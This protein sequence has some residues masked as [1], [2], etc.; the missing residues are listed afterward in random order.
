MTQDATPSRL[1]LVSALV[2]VYL[3]WGST[4]LAIH[5]A[6]ESMPPFLMAGARWVLAGALLYAWRRA[7]GDAAPTWRNW[8][9]AAVVGM[10][11][12]VGGNGLVSWAQ[13][14]VPSGF[15][16]LLIA[17]VPVWMALLDWLRPGGAA[18]T[19]RVWA[20]VLLGLAGVSLLVGPAALGRV[21]EAGP[22]FLAGVG[23]ILLASFSWANGSL[24]SR[25]APMPKSSLLGAAMQMLAGGLALTALGL[26]SGE[27]REV[28]I[29]A[30]SAR[31]WLAWG[32]LVVF[33]S[34]VA[35]SAYVWLLKVTRAELVATYAFVNPV[36]AVLLGALLAGE[37]FSAL[38]GVA[39]GLIVLAVAVIVTAPRPGAKAKPPVAAAS[40]MSKEF[41]IDTREG[42][43]HRLSH[44]TAECGLDRIPEGARQERES[45]L[46]ATMVMKTRHYRACPRC[47]AP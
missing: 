2:A 19:P 39:A 33:G 44:A 1:A 10:L 22:L 46:D 32:F 47:Y 35:Y 20:G 45:E 15:T 18:P 23:L 14:F 11:L 12:I 37:R 24:W 26:L 17:V 31:A 40:A 5:Y 41:V 13:Q 21:D 8:R 16:A 27:A 4:Y 25:R 42:V 9:A 6:V 38:T 29:P 7:K 34:I 28:D 43:I 36:V 30:V 3:I